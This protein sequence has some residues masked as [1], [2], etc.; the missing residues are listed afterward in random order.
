MQRN[1]GTLVGMW[2]MKRI[3]RNTVVNRRKQ[4]NTKKYRGLKELK[5]EMCIKGERDRQ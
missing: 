4:W 5:S 3:K 1:I 2:G